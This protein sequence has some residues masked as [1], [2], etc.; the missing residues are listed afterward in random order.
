[1]SDSELS[2]APSTSIAS[3]KDPWSS[4]T[5]IRSAA[6]SASSITAPNPARNTRHIEM[7]RPVVPKL[8]RSTAKRRRART[9]AEEEDLETTQARNIEQFQS[10][11]DEELVDDVGDDNSIDSSSLLAGSQVVSQT[12]SRSSSISNAPRQ[13]RKLVSDIWKH[14]ELIENNSMKCNYCYTI[15]K[16]IGGTRV[17]R[18][19]LIKEYRIDSANRQAVATATYLHGT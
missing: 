19:H 8:I 6:S 15:Y 7:R 18:N 9:N 14:Y 12:T 13:G 3:R 17:P 2:T 11:D 5:G 4:F 1:M 16:L 10:E